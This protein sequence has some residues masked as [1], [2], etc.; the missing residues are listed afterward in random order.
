MIPSRAAQANVAFV[1]SSLHESPSQGGVKEMLP[2]N[3][4]AQISRINEWIVSAGNP[5]ATYSMKQEKR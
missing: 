4:M 5:I 1:L 2:A 3:I